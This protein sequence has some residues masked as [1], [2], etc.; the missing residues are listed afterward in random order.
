[1]CW[2]KGSIVEG[3]EGIAKKWDKIVFFSPSSS[4]DEHILPPSFAS[5]I[6]K[7]QPTQ[8]KEE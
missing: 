8:K 7:K 2:E 4:F 6:G 5:I 1:M 3:K